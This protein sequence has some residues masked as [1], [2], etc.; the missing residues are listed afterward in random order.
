MSEDKNKSEF[1]KLFDELFKDDKKSNNED[2]K[3]NKEVEDDVIETLFNEDESNKSTDIS[4]EIEKTSEEEEEEEDDNDNFDWLKDLIDEIDKEEKEKKKNEQ[5]QPPTI[6]KPIKPSFT[7]KLKDKPRPPAP[8]EHIANWGLGQKTVIMPVRDNYKQEHR[9]SFFSRNKIHIFYLSLILIFC[10]CVSFYI[11]TEKNIKNNCY[12]SNVVVRNVFSG[13]KILLDTNEISHSGKEVVEKGYIDAQIS[14]IMY[15]LLK[16]GDKVIDA[17][18]G[19]GYYTLYLA[20][21]VGNQGKVYSFEARRHIF[22]LLDSSIR[23]NRLTNVRTFNKVLFGENTKLMLDMQDHQRRSNF[24]V[25]NI[26]LEQENIYANYDNSEV[27]DSATLDSVLDGITNVSMLH[28]NTHGSE[29]SIIL[30]AKKLIATSPKIKIITSW[31]KYQMAKYVNI[32]SVVTQLLDNGFR[33]WLIKPSNGKLIELSRIEHIMQVERGRF[34][35]A[36]TLN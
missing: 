17:G 22:E 15:S 7:S 30:G 32:Q 20:R 6:Q 13:D 9:D 25:A 16:P 1:D 28:I 11:N 12:G 29:L 33:F 24:G 10:G 8:P 18:A 36:K 23:I 26:I 4:S 19:F 31:S 21:I 27:V 35:I 14:N 5:N 2:Q 34:L 3:Q